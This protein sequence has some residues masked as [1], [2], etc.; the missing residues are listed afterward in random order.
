MH[1]RDEI[2]KMHSLILNQFQ[3]SLFT[4]MFKCSWSMAGYDVEYE[5][6]ESFKEILF[7]FNEH[8]CTVNNCENISFIQCSHCRKILC[9][10]CFLEDYHFHDI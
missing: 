8:T 3:S 6:F 2:C 9:L 10:G 1:K 4:E 5:P 7:N